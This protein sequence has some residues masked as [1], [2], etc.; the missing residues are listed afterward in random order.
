M[1]YLFFLL[2]SISLHAQNII[3]GNIFSEQGYILQNVLVVNMRTNRQTSSNTEG[4]FSIEASAN[5]ELRFVKDN[6]ER[7]SHKVFNKDFSNLFSI[8]LIHKP[9][10]IEEVKLAFSPTGN[11]NKDMNFNSSKK[12]AKLNKDI[13][14]YVKK[15]MVE[16]QPKSKI[17]SSF[18]SKDPYE[19]QLNLFSI[20]L[21]EGSSNGI[22]GLLLNDDFTKNKRKPTFSE[23]KDFH[24][25]VKDTFYGEYYIKQGLNEADFDAY[26]FFLDNNYQFSENYFANFDLLKIEQ[27]LKILLKKFIK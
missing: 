3:S 21:I 8:T 2:S 14:E 7:T 4:F 12:V 20:N 13:A 22:V 19:G 11:I 1:K 17:I 15:P 18:A 5:D 23:I 26:I 9:T 10:E 25:K 24:K 27:L 16:I 6:Y